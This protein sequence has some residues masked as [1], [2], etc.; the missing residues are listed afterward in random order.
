ME[1]EFTEDELTLGPCKYECKHSLFLSYIF[2][3]MTHF[4]PDL[5][6]TADVQ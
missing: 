2:L 6:H 1:E 4:F 3:K 5:D